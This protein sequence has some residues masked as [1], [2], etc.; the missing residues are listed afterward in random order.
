MREKEGDSGRRE[1][2]RERECSV[3][4]PRDREREGD[5]VCMCMSGKVHARANGRGGERER[6]S[7]REHVCTTMGL[8]T[9]I[10]FETKCP[11]QQAR[12]AYHLHKETLF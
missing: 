8:W 2:G 11:V 9:N 5:R 7:V 10:T 6:E 12:C 3:Y 4:I 1:N